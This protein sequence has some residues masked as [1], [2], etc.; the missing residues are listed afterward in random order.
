MQLSQATTRELEME[1]LRRAI[2]A[3]EKEIQRI[4][5]EVIPGMRRKQ[6]RRHIELT[7]Q[8]IYQQQ[9]EAR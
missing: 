9:D 3:A 2:H 5:Q 1:Q 6:L 8:Q 7:R 4:T